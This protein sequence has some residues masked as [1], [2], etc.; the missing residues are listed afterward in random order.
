MLAQ[1]KEREVVSELHR[2]PGL[3]LH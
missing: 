1:R 2:A 3:L